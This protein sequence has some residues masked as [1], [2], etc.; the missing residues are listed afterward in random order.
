MFFHPPHS[1]GRGGSRS[2]AA[3]DRIV[4]QT[5]VVVIV[6]CG[7]KSTTQFNGENSGSAPQTD[8]GDGVEDDNG[9][10][11]HDHLGKSKW[12]TLRN[13]PPENL[14]QLEQ[15]F[16]QVVVDGSSSCVLENLKVDSVVAQKVLQGEIMASSMKKALQMVV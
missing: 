4:P 1:I 7:S 10:F 12:K 8:V 5:Q 13:A 11:G 9:S 16:E 6:P 2:A 3:I 14:G 15:M